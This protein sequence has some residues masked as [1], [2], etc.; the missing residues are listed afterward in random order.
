[1][2]LSE[3]ALNETK[4]R[5]EYEQCEYANSCL[6]SAYKAFASLLKDEH[7]GMSI[8]FTKEFLDKL[9]DGL[10]LTPINDSDFVATE[11]TIIESPEYL[12]ERNLKSK[13]QCPRMSSLFR[14]EHIDGNIEYNDVDRTIFIDTNH[15]NTTWNSG[16]CSSI[17]N[18]MFPIKMPYYPTKEKYKLYGKTYFLTDDGK[19]E[20]DK[21][22]GEFNYEVIDYMITPSG[23]Q[24][25]LNKI[26]DGRNDK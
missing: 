3:W 8:Q 10:P 26:W 17:V 23:E 6:D 20:T 15:D 13:I 2:K 21:H 16:Y 11:D 18:E 1:M 25:E 19:D 22:I 5:K 4:L 24:I 7:S 12:K 14:K 9:I